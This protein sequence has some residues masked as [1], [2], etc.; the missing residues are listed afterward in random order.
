MIAIPEQSDLCRLALQHDTDKGTTYTQAYHRLLGHVRDQ[1]LRVLEIGLY[2]GGSLRMWRDYL[3]NATLHGIDI[4]PRA[5]AY[6]DEIPNAQVRLVD[7]GDA[8]ALDRFVAELGGNYDFILDDGGH[9]MV[10]QIVSFE[11]LWPQVM[12]GG[13]YAVEDLGTSY[14]K[15]Y[16][17]EDLGHPATAVAYVKD[18]VDAVNRRD[19]LAPPP[20][21]TSAV[22]PVLAAQVRRDVAS[23]HFHP[24]LALI[25]K[26]F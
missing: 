7:Q 25:V 21:T 23:V 16:G 2:N 20:N 1:R 19:I 8:A 24:G 4:E 26:K 5:L 12:P 3:P 13:V 11:V 18:L 9:T 22:H 6:Q 17:G 15:E 10:Q 14:F